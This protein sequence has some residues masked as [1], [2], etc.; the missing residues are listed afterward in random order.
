MFDNLSFGCN[1][2]DGQM[3]VDVSNVKQC[4]AWLAEYWEKWVE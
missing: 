1:P 2:K 3:L 4:D